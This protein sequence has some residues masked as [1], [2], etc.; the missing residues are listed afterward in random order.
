MYEVRN[1]ARTTEKEQR[2]QQPRA[3][4]ARGEPEAPVAHAACGA[5]RARMGAPC[6]SE[7]ATPLPWGGWNTLLGVEGRNADTL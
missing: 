7:K 6:E 2:A 3:G 4:D 5:R 1:I